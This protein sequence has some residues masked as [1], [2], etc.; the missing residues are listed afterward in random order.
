[1]PQLPG[2]LPTPMVTDLPGL[3]LLISHRRSRAGVVGHAMRARSAW[4]MP[5][6]AERWREST[7]AAIAME[8][9]GAKRERI[10]AAV[11]LDRPA[12]PMKWTRGF[13]PL[14]RT[15]IS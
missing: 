6:G 15:D 14:R 9:L 12:R 11:G 4:P 5:D 1:M 8:E 10:A 7:D 3:L 13:D 2:V